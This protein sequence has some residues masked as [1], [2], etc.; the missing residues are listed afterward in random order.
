MDKEPQGEV[1]LQ[2]Y[3][4]HLLKIIIMPVSSFLRK[5]QKHFFFLSVKVCVGERGG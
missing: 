2:L 1:N 4:H 5:P 3:I